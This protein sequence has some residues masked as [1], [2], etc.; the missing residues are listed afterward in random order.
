[1]SATIAFLPQPGE[2]RWLRSRGKVYKDAGGAAVR[3]TGS[4]TDITERKLVEEELRARQRM[5]DLAQKT[6][7][8]VA[9]DW[10][11]DAGAHQNRWPPELE[12]M[13]GL[14]P[15]TWP[16]S[17]ALFGLVRESW[18]KLVHPDDWAAVREAINHAYRTGD[19]AFEYRVVHPDGSVTGCSPR[20]GCSSTTEGKPVRMVGLIQ[21]VTQLRTAEDELKRMERQL[22][23]AQRL[24]SVGTLAGAW[25]T[26]ST[27]SSARSSAMARWRC[28]MRHP[29][30]ACAATWRASSL[31]ASADER[32]STASSPFSRSG[33]GERVAVHVEAVVREALELL[34]A[35]LPDNVRIESELRAG[36][37]AMLGDPTQVHQVL[38]NLAT[39]GVQA[40]SD[41]GGALRVS[42]EALRLDDLI[43]R[44]RAGACRRLDRTE[45]IDAGVGIA[46][47]IME[48]IFDPSS[49]RKEVGVGTGLGF[50]W[51]T[52]SSPELGGAVMWRA[53]WA[54]AALSP[55]TCTRS[56]E[57]V[58]LPRSRLPPCRA[59]IGS[60]FWWWT[61]RSRWSG[62]AT[63]TLAELG[64]ERG[65]T[66]S[67]AR[68]RP[69]APILMGSML[70]SPMSACRECRDDADPRGARHPARH[71]IVLVSGYVGKKSRGTAYNAGATRF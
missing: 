32:W 60:A 58:D 25:R 18:K 35:S 66:S 3:M 50:R 71:P 30:A 20:G 48:R 47:G 19:V 55:C 6:A 23:H 53:R 24:E 34:S 65:F 59:A 68:S 38:T 17:F 67:V 56:G 36:R 46:P 26:I 29:A 63:R 16:G 14:A 33:V 70:S 54:R 69:F 52:A 49:P 5:L 61:T 57:A 11:V 64:Y 9:F 10:R 28:A 43:L 12:A 40:M 41:S 8:A 42:L 1:M 7:R 22:R 4:L 44:P 45:I 62:L 31:P 15:G 51:C 27:I 21:D 13:Y 39:N 37:A 2:V